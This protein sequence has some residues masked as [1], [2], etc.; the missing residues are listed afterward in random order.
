MLRL[1]LRSIHLEEVDRLLGM[2]AR[3]IMEGAGRDVVRLALAH[4]GVVFQQVLDL[5][6]IGRGLGVEDAFCFRS[7][8]RTQVSWEGKR[9]RKRCV[10]LGCGR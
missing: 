5:G 4:E 3:D 9:R 10:E 8:D 2:L 6:A 7:F 1:E